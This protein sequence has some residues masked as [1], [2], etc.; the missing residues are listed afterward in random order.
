MNSKTYIGIIKA[1][2][3]GI[4]DHALAIDEIKDC[5]DSAIDYLAHRKG[6]QAAIDTAIKVLRDAKRITPESLLK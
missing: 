6:D 5:I 4:E 3:Q 2:T 1:L